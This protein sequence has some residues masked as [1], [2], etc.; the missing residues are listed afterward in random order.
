MIKSGSQ[1]RDSIVDVWGPRTPYAECWP[2]RVDEHLTE[3]PDRWVQSACML[4]ANG[5]G[6][7]IGVKDGR[8]VGVRGRPED[9]VNR[10]R[11]GPKGLHGWRANASADRLTR[12]LI[13][14]GGVLEEATWDEA[15]ELI[16][17]HSKE[18]I[19]DY[20]AN[21]MGF[22]HSGQLLLEEYYTLSLIAL[23][24]LGTTHLDAN[25]RL[26]TSTAETALRESFGSDGQPGC[27]EDIDLASVIFHIGHNVASQ[28]TVLWSRILDRLHG[29]NPPRLVVVDP[30]RTATAEQ[31]HLHLAPR[32]GTNLALMNGLLHL[33]IRNG[34]VDADYIEK[35]TVGFEAL[36][37]LV[38]RYPPERV[39]EICDIPPARLEEAAE[40]LGSAPTLVSTVLLG[41]YQSPHATASAVQVNNLH[42]IR[43]MIG[44]PGCSVFQMNGQPAAQNSR[45]CGAS[46]SYPGMRNWQN[47][48][49][50]EE[51]ARIWNVEARNIP[52]YTEPT[53]AMEIFRRAEQGSLR[54]LWITCTN[55]VVSLPELSRIR[56]ILSK[57]GLFLVVQDAF[58]TET[59]QLAD[60]VLPAAMWGEKT[61]T[62]TNTE[63]T[64]HLAHKAV[65]PPGEARADFD[66]W[67]DYARRMDLR[68]K[69][70]LPLVK[71][72]TQE[73]AF[74]SWC[75]MSSG[76]PC[77]YSGL[78]Y[79]M[80]TGS[81]GI[82]WPCNEQ[83][84]DG[85]PR[86][87]TDGFFNTDASY[88]Q[89]FGHTLLSGSEQSP[90][91]YRK[92]NPAGRARI[93]AADYEPPAEV[94]GEAY[95]FTLTTGRVLYHW[96]T[97]TK[98]G[99]VQ[100]LQEAAP[101]AFVQISE[102]DALAA[103]VRPN[104][105]V[106]VRT[107]RGR[108]VARAHV[109]NIRSR[110]LFVPFHYGYWDL[111]DREAG[112]RQRAANEMTAPDCDP[113]SMQPYFKSSAAQLSRIGDKTGA[114]PMS[115]NPEVARASV[116]RSA[117]DAVSIF[118]SAATP[119]VPGLHV[120]VYLA[121]VW[122]GEQALAAAYVNVAQRHSDSADVKT[123]CEAFAARSRRYVAEL[124]PFMV[125]YGSNDE[126]GT[127]LIS[128]LFTGLRTGNL[129]MLM[130]LH[131]LHT[132]T[133]HLGVG[134]FALKQAASAL[135]DGALQQAL[136]AR[137][138]E[139]SVEQ[140]WLSR[141]IRAVAAQALVVPAM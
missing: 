95:P 49:H 69:D 117:Y 116:E 122:K 131:D 104:E 64:V 71:W 85:K 48:A 31:A 28:Q 46:G 78:T 97:R 61:G 76:R 32:M 47:P 12:P 77:D 126:G 90:E 125:Q 133:G 39:A 137:M 109:G 138:E 62:F 6:L 42:L 51:I 23:G 8:M 89:G 123:R 127:P 16:V 70:G 139:L 119:K 141:E 56:R 29:A 54:F 68:D 106:E 26:C 91:A 72:S 107:R 50:V 135:K 13:R 105:W 94:P 41:V 7:D 55:P 22:Y 113:V 84:P 74:D 124:E 80:L 99:R 96:H 111:T 112:D 73:E 9:H 128:A 27:Y 14:R 102:Q 63:R 86:L 18:L 57:P 34:N 75:R 1:S 4:C 134:F 115:Y 67:V 130:D 118:Q 83:F 120:P 25:T 103:G 100:A 87:Y 98:T 140:G 45:E 93:K 3:Q 5:C 66:I 121:V 88:T 30:R 92:H 44:K 81:S 33:L 110:H 2:V 59:A 10:G 53:H 15:M 52:S 60:V 114:L 65:E 132:L 129:G 36:A 58:L 17:A 82:R 79:A 20:T 101:E 24:G 108:I 40:L 43:G 37:E 11:L 21:T 19:R 38:S 35:H 136:S